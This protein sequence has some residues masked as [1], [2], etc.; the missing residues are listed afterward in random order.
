MKLVKVLTPGYVRGNSKKGQILPF[1]GSETELENLI[2]AGHA[3]LVEDTGKVEDLEAKVAGLEQE[4][5][6]L[7]A[8]LEEATK[9]IEE[10]TAPKE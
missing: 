10:L 4:N 1:T 3:E 6:I 8:Q 2:E 5:A 9:Q 7:K